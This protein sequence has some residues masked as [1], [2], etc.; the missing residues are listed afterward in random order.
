MK[1]AWRAAGIPLGVVIGILDRDF[2]TGA[3]GAVAITAVL[4]AIPRRK[5]EES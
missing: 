1:G 3:I 4:Q 5:K 2:W